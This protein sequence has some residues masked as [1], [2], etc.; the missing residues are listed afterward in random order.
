MYSTWYLILA[1]TMSGSECIVYLPTTNG[2][3]EEA[4]LAKLVFNSEYL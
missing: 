2:T 3:L 4:E 1:L